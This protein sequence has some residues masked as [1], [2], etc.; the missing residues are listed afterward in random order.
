MNRKQQDVIDYLY[1][2]NQT[3]KLDRKGVKL[4]LRNT[5]RRKLAKAGKKLG[6]KRLMQY[7]SISI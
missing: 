3:L 6:R 1:A 5:Q 4:D 7:A 2:E